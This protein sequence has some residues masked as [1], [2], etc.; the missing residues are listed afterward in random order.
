MAFYIIYFC[1]RQQSVQFSNQMMDRQMTVYT[2]SY[3]YYPLALGAYG[4]QVS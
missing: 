4:Y 3:I 1:I 2:I